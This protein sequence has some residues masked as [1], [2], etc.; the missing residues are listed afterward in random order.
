[1]E[2]NKGTP[3]L[4]ID[5]HSSNNNFG[6]VAGRQKTFKQAVEGERS[7]LPEDAR[8]EAAA[9]NYDG[10]HSEPEEEAPPVPPNRLLLFIILPL[11]LLL[12]PPL[13]P[14]LPPALEPSPLL[15]L[16]LHF[17]SLEPHPPSMVD[18]I[19]KYQQA[20]KE[21][22]IGAQEPHAPPVDD[23]IPPKGPRVLNAQQIVLDKLKNVVEAR[24]SLEQALQVQKMEL[25]NS[26]RYLSH[27]GGMGR[28]GGINMDTP[29][30]V[31][32]RDPELTGPCGP[33]ENST[34][35]GDP[36][37]EIN[38]KENVDTPENREDNLGPQGSVDVV[39]PENTPS[40]CTHIDTPYPNN[41]LTVE[42][43]GIIQN[44]NNEDQFTSGS[45]KFEQGSL[46]KSEGFTEVKFRKSRRKRSL[47][48]I[49][50]VSVRKESLGPEQISEDGELGWTTW[51]P[52]Q[53][54]TT[55]P[56]AELLF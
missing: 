5:T 36:S 29:E 19:T 21:A 26:S 28:I 13:P 52:S 24:K 15:L 31:S 56:G 38:F 25:D 9:T 22:M 46:E 7:P 4:H 11:S 10:A 40:W 23:S 32:T 43:R 30:M 20:L 42:D 3:Y 35:C 34:G 44:G 53:G 2:G 45:V 18:S 1:M 17:L 50:D 6:E 16:N 12:R 48:T 14:C 55:T 49:K 41:T 39:L 8:F 27:I 47:G 33:K 37:F 54:D 51:F